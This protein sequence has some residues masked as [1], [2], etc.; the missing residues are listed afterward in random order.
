MT[1]ENA[2]RRLED[3]SQDLS[4]SQRL[5]IST[6]LR[7]FTLDCYMKDEWK[8]ADEELP[9][10]QHTVLAYYLNDCKKGRT[11]KAMYIEPYSILAEDFYEDWMDYGY[12]SEEKDNYYV[13][14]G[15]YER[16]ENSDYG[17]YM[18]ND[19]VLFWQELPNEPSKDTF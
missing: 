4:Y 1:I 15:W 5:A 17:Y 6:L 19:R 13:K 16:V 14:S 9:K 2:I 12:Y 11:V 10:S 3:D 8:D 7:A 18:I